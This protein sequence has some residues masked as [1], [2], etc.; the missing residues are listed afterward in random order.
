MFEMSAWCVVVSLV[1]A[2]GV[3]FDARGHQPLWRL[4]AIAWAAFVGITWVGIILYLVARLRRPRL[5]EA[6]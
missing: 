6:R 3:W 1:L 4:P 5:A 2:A